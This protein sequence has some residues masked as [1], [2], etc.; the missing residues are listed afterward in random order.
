MSGLW[1]LFAIPL[2][3]GGQPAQPGQ[4]PD[5]SSLQGEADAYQRMTI[6]VAVEGK[7]PY[8]F[9]IDTGSQRT[10]VSTALAQNLALR[11]G[12]Q[13]RVMGIAGASRVATAEVDELAFGQRQVNGLTVPLLEG[14]HMGA[15]GII[16]TDSLQH[17]R[18]LLDF[19][20]NVME[21]GPGKQLGG[22]AGYEIIVRARKRNGRLILTDADIDG[23]RVDVVVD[24]GASGTIGNRALQ[25]ALREKAG[26]TGQLYSVTGQSIPAQLG[27]AGQLTIGKLGVE[28]VLIAFSD[29]PAFRELKLNRRPAI[30][31]GMREMR[32]FKRIAI[33]FPTRKVLFDLPDH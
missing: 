2:I 26:G 8:R 22:N 9:L 13:V 25:R 19:T 17:D 27:T 32:A 1:T 12:P 20:R 16:G 21:V 33:D 24:T 11:G 18:V 3:L 6:P 28:N 10:V 15:D 14:Q 7:G 23:V 4:T 30:F 5:E 31:L 29:A